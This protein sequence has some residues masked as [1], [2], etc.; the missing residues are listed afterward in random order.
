MCDGLPRVCQHLVPVV[1]AQ[2]LSIDPHTADS[3]DLIVAHSGGE[4]KGLE[5][6]SGHA[7]RKGGPGVWDSAWQG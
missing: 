4:T 7:T 3:Y 2:A 6:V 1:P 5:L